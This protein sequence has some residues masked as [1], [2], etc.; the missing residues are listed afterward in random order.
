MELAR[1]GRPREDHY[2]LADARVVHRLCEQ[3]YGLRTEAP[4]TTRT[5][6]DP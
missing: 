4:L 1:A 5:E 3:G 6:E 2:E